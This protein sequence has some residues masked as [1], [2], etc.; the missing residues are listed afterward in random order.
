MIDLNKTQL[1]AVKIRGTNVV[2]FASAGAGKTTVLVRRL[3]ERITIDKIPLNNILAMTFT[4]AA[5]GNMKN[6][7]RNELGKKRQE[8][9]KLQD[10]NELAFIDEQLSG[11]ENTDISTIHSFCLKIVKKY[12]Y[13]LGLT[14]KTLTNILSGAQ[15]EEICDELLDKIIEEELAKDQRRLIELTEAISSEIFAFSILKKTILAIYEAAMNKKD[16]FYGIRWAVWMLI[17]FICASVI[18]TYL[19]H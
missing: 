3:L 11:I 17:G 19:H 9:L 15:S 2:V 6:R 18:I 1:E 14:Q 13:R 10:T 7:L 4:E 5:A 12:Y 16:P 8:A